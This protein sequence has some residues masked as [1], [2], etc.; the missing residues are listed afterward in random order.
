MYATSES[1]ESIIPKSENG[2]KLDTFLTTEMVDS[3]FLSDGM[4]LNVYRYRNTEDY[5]V[6]VTNTTQTN[7]KIEDNRNSDFVYTNRSE[8]GTI[9]EYAAYVMG[10]DYN[11]K[12]YINGT[13][14]VIN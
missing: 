14:I 5:Y 6:F 2:W 4:L 9:K 11:Y 12:L 10:Y 7:A 3:R 13:E 8:N 1:T